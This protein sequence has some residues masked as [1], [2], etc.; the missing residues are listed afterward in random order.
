MALSLIVA[1]LLLTGIASAEERAAATGAQTTEI[2]VRYES[3]DLN[4]P[5]GVRRLLVRIGNA[6][7]ESCGA[8]LFS[9][10]EIRNAALASQC[11]KDAIDDAVHRIGS[12]LLSAAASEERR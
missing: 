4:S 5:A 12:P 1:P 10:P 2:H 6:A 3:R 7:L 9:L 8:S 11:Y